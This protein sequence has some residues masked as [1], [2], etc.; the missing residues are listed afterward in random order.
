MPLNNKNVYLNFYQVFFNDVE[1][2]KVDLDS[3]A[4]RYK[5]ECDDESNLRHSFLSDRTLILVDKANFRGQ[6]LEHLIRQWSD[7]ESKLDNQ[8]A[9]LTQVCRFI[10]FY[11]LFFMLLKKFLLRTFIFLCSP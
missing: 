3:L 8:H 7:I 6:H 10:L 9:F 2:H 1:R 11:F 5:L 4:E